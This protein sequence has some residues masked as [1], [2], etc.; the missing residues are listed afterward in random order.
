MKKGKLYSWH[1]NGYGVVSVTV[2]ERYFLHVTDIAEIP[3]DLE[4]PPIG[5]TVHFD[6]APPHGNGKLPRATNAVVI[7][8]AVE[9]ETTEG[10]AL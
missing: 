3:D 2:K 8:P 9:T 10:G 6:V 5:S 7:P 1:D 4:T